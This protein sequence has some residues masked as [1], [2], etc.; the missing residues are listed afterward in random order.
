MKT[1]LKLIITLT[2]LVLISSCTCSG[3]AG[4][5]SEKTTTETKTI[6]YPDGKVKTTEKKDKDS[7]AGELSVNKSFLVKNANNQNSRKS[8]VDS[9]QGTKSDSLLDRKNPIIKDKL[10]KVDNQ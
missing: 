2:S 9:K 7:I 4:F 8:Y 3:N 5:H 10:A 6:T 1:Y